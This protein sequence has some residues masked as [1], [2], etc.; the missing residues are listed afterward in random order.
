[1]SSSRRGRPANQPPMHYRRPDIV[2]E[3]GLSVT[4][5]LASGKSTAYTFTDLGPPTALLL[6][7]IEA[8]ARCIAPVGGW[9]SPY[10]CE[11]G[12]HKLRSFY[13]YTQALEP[14]ITRIEQVTPSVWNSWKATKQSTSVWN[15]ALKLTRVILRKA[16]GLPE[17]TQVA[18]RQ[19]LSHPRK[20][21]KKV[22]LSR[23]EFKR[24]ELECWRVFD[25]ACR[26]IEANLLEYQRLQTVVTNG[27]ATKSEQV[28]Y[29]A[30]AALLYDGQALGREQFP[31]L[32]KS[33][34]NPSLPTADSFYL[35][36]LE[37]YSAMLLFAALRGY[38]PGMIYD[39]R[40]G[41]QRPDGGLD[42]VAVRNVQVVKPRR[43]RK[44]AVARD[45]LQDAGRR[46]AGNLYKRLIEATRPARE[47]LA[48]NGLSTDMLFL[49][50][51]RRA[52]FS[53]SGAFIT[54]R[55]IRMAVR[56]L[57][58]LPSWLTTTDNQGKSILVSLRLMRRS[59]QVIN[60]EPRFNSERV[61]DEVY[62][63]PDE[64]IVE[65]SAEVI[66]QGQLD[67]VEHAKTTMQL[68][69]L[70]D[71]D[72]TL[73]RKT[74]EVLA[75]RLGISSG[76]IKLLLLGNLDTP[77]ASCL[78]FENSPF[79]EGSCRAS[80]LLCL[81]CSNAVVA[82]KHLPRLV[83]LRCALEATASAITSHVWEADYRQHYDRLQHLLST[84]FTSGE[85]S[86]A[87]A[88]VSRSEIA[89]I[90]NL[91]QRKLDA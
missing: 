53:P 52:D 34:G 28:M 19:P 35:G 44:R 37:V 43:G 32:R 62:V 58:S 59:E 85:V 15:S 25:A 69:T 26:R 54:G 84:C 13:R 55:K 1:M 8:F 72:L 51:S 65:E 27:K 83:A 24:V 11:G 87:K 46:S 29:E 47:F 30:I 20:R 88:T 5:T 61:H 18:M 64:G 3:D 80:F 33:V 14:P 23:K 77:V 42:E 36:S 63:L 41:H 57:P 10:T 79:N 81:A 74:P 4:M 66:I 39:L 2:S 60:R 68:R 6:E 76:R 38:T 16:T 70:S 12:S 73:A 9:D 82:P 40:S 48:A 86:V 45:N 89:A 75:K 50:Y 22:S 67:A 91:L 78:D 56:N 49:A 17:A 31:H 7:L 71:E 90:E 21:T